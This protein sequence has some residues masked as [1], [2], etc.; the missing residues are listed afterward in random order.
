MYKNSKNLIRTTAL[1]M[2]NERGLEAVGVREI[3]RE[4]GMSPG[5]ISY[6]FP[7]KNDL[8]VEIY[9]EFVERTLICLNE[10]RSTTRPRPSHLYGLLIRIMEVQQLY[11][12]LFL[13]F[14]YLTGIEALA[15]EVYQNQVRWKKE[16]AIQMKQWKGEGL[17]Y[18]HSG[19]E[20]ST[21]FEMTKLILI[22]RFTDSK[23]H[24]RDLSSE[25][26]E[27]VYQGRLSSL[28]R[29]YFRDENI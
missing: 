6:Y 16:I 24:A 7:S 23:I 11:R 9:R 21:F 4:L 19:D 15:Q 8:I 28:F 25:E 26:S 29:L 22:Y 3:G 13:S 5:N 27:K 14:N 20:E 17:V 18:A 10:F 12:C 2:F 1:A